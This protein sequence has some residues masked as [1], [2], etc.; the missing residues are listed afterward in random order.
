MVDV[1]YVL[2]ILS[3][4]LIA[5]VGFIGKYIFESIG[6]IDKTLIEEKGNIKNN[7][8]EIAIVQEQVDEHSEKLVELEHSLDI[9]ISYVKDELKSL[10][11]RIK[12]NMNDLRKSI[13]DDIYG[14]D[15]KFDKFGNDQKVSNVEFV[16]LIEGLLNMVS[17]E[18]QTKNECKVC[19][20][21]RDNS[22]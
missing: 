13:R 3:T 12:D 19:L 2:G 7:I 20:E 6:N 17:R 18:Y 10:D 11:G 14:L 22:K 21:E 16:R 4:I 8:K 9:S 5:I 1:I 15:K